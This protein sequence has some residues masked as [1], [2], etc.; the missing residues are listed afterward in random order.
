MIDKTGVEGAI[1]Y[2]MGLKLGAHPT[3]VMKRLPETQKEESGEAHR[4][5]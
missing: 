5:I 4:D 3:C 1:E 2:F